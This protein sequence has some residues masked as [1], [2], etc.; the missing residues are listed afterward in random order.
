M[1]KPYMMARALRNTTAVLRIAFG[2]LLAMFGAACSDGNP[3]AA[4]QLPRVAMEMLVD[5]SRA[6]SFENVRFGPASARFAPL[7]GN[8]INLGFTR[9]AAWLRLT[10]ESATDRRVLLALSPNFVDEVDV[11]VLKSGH[12]GDD[13]GVTHFAMGD[14]RPLRDDALS[15]LDHVVPLHLTAHEAT[16]VLVRVAAVNSAL[17]LAATLYSPSEHTFRT[18]VS[19]LASGAWFG[20]MAVL[21]IIQLVFFYFDRKPYFILLAFSTFV[22]M[23]VYMGTLGL[24]RLFLFPEGGVGNDLFTAG[25]SWFGL[26]ASAVAVASILELPQRAPWLNRI[27]LGGAVIGVMGVVFAFAGANLMFADITSITIMVLATLAAVQGIRTVSRDE[28]GSGLRASAFCVLWIGLAATIAQRTGVGPLPNWMAASYGVS[29][30]I[31]TI[32]LTGALG[33][34]LR[35]AEAANR[36]MR[37]EALLAAQ[38]AEKR[39]N[40]LVDEKTRE[41]ATAKQVAEEALRAELA[42]Q[43]EQVRFMEVISHQYRTP[44]A[45]IR[46]HVD[47]IGLSLP[48]ND[49]ANRRRIERVRSGIA[50]LVEV[51]EVNLSRSRLQGP[52]FRPERRLLSPAAV[53]SSAAA[54]ARDLL[55]SPIVTEIDPEAEEARALADAGMLELAIINLLENGVKYSRS[56]GREP[57]SLRCRVDGPSVVIIVEDRGIGIPAGEIDIILRQFVRGSNVQAIEGTGT[58]LSLVSRIVAAHEGKVEIESEEGRGTVVRIILPL[59]AADQLSGAGR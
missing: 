51:L 34:R 31:Q 30:I 10:I 41:L 46:S 26:A 29:C 11:Y 9:K 14:H 22:A 5:E 18:T 24:S 27:F 59:V 28:S 16:Q 58:G 36:V 44:L 49:E 4:R 8:R 57:V 2:I 12:T 13:R 15:G 48:P 20:G 56:S 45:A 52:F 35:A 54:R 37:E 39:A 17:N 55:Q 1:R 38:T 42:S 21:L 19:A 7:A 43:Q 6:L 32:L 23:L 3:S 33:V 50:K 53:V 47:N 25:T 40:Q